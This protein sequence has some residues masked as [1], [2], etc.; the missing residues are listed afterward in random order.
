MRAVV[1]GVLLVLA[2]TAC[3][4]DV[5][6]PGA[7]PSPSAGASA[8]EERTDEPTDGP[9]DGPSP[10][11]PP[12]PSTPDIEEVVANLPRCDEVWVADRQLPL[13]Y[14]GCKLPGGGLDLGA[15]LQCVEGPGLAAHRDRFWARLGEPVEDSGGGGTA[16]D[17]EHAAG[18]AACQGG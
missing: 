9:T 16:Q 3:S 2:L 18:V 14:A 17:P 4:G 5:A 1:P 11:P 15:V 7:G 6:G 13:D 12:S 10:T 8:S